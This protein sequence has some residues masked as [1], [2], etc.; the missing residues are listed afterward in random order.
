M[1]RKGGH[2]VSKIKFLFL[3]Q[4]ITAATLALLLLSLTAYSRAQ[5][6]TTPYTANAGAG[7]S[8]LVGAVSSRL[9]DGW[10]I[11]FGAGYNFTKHFTTTLD[12]TYNG[13]GVSRNVLN[14]AGVPSGNSHMQSFTVN[15]K[16]RLNRRSKFDPYVIGGVGY[17]RRTVEFT[18]PAL[19]PVLIFDPFFGGFFNTL[20]PANEVLGRLIA[21]GV[22]GCLGGGFDIK[23][24]DNGV[25]FFSEARYHY[26]NTGRIVTRMFAVLVIAS[27]APFS[28][29]V[30]TF[31]SKSSRWPETKTGSPRL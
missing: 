3:Q 5:D 12:Y 2:M 4:P 17:Y 7:V 19:V 9:N 10:H 24:G 20:V 21:D 14:E 1:D 29:P 8:P 31:I 6:D 15:P 11:T 23:L 28:L 27:S 30:T 16:L 13:F 26:A 22:G 25:K 18:R